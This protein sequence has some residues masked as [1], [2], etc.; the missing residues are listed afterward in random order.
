MA[1]LVLNS[2][3]TMPIIGYGTFQVR[4]SEVVYRVLEAA[5]SAGYRSIDTASVY[6]NEE[7]IGHSFKKLLPKYNLKRSDLFITSKLGPKDQG[8]GH[9]YDA[10]VQSI[11]RLQCNYLDL[12]LIHWPGTQGLKQDNCD[13]SLR[14]SESWKDMEK[15]CAE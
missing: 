4:G 10:C 15:L 2:G 14:R 6:R 9:C 7:D 11:S 1:K 8:S 13:N 3:Q 5:I 12:Y